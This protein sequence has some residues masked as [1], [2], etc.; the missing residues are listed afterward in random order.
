MVCTGGA[1]M[2]RREGLEGLDVDRR[3][4]EGLPVAHVCRVSGMIPLEPNEYRTWV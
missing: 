4:Y 1:Q 3:R 2:G